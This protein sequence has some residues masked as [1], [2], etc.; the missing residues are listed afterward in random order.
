MN[1][2]QIHAPDTTSLLCEASWEVCNQIGGIYTVVRSKVPTT[3]ETWG[4]R[5]C[6]IGPYI[7]GKSGVE[8]EECPPA[9]PFGRAVKGMQDAGLDARYGHWLVPGHPITVLFNP[10]S[11]A[12]HLNEIKYLAWEHHAISLLHSDEL[13]DQVV[14]FGYLCEQF[15]RLL[16]EAEAPRT[17]I[18]GLFHEWMAGSAVPEIRRANLPMGVIFN[19]HATQLGRFLAMESAEYQDRIPGLDW[20]ETARR[21]KLEPQVMFERAAAREA[22]VFATVSKVTSYEC[23][24]LLG[25]KPDVILPNGLNIERFVALHEFQNLHRIFKEKIHQFVIGHFFPSYTFDLDRTLYFFT[26]G[27]YE[28]GNKGFDLTI[29]SLARL[30]WKMKQAQTNCTVVFFLITNGAYRCINA[31][32]L[33]TRAVMEEIR[34]NCEAIQGQIGKRLFAATTMGQSP[35]MDSLVDEY[36]RLRLRR[37]LQAWRAARTPPVMTHDMNDEASDPVILQFRACGL[38][39]LPEDPVKVVFH[40]DFI[41]TSDPLFGMDYDQFVR[42]CHF[43]MF[44][45]R[46][47]PFGYAPLECAALGIPSATSDMSGFGAYVNEEIPDHDEHGLFVVKRRGVSFEEAAEQLAEQAFQIARLGRRERIALRNRVESTAELFDWKNLIAHYESAFQL[48]LGRIGSS[49][50]GA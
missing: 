2:E 12:R 43:G 29:E 18:L 36:W 34:Q 41:T 40:P 46:Y 48:A 23:E 39:N 15:F 5:Y 33:R 28:Y 25:R 30:N 13:I 35:P 19:T 20:H 7:E 45:S 26:S 22:H 49:R 1:I 44:P 24:H 16:C 31:E 10:R 37:N 42:G 9:G 47:E 6:A 50:S 27:R 14:L 32:L 3:A 21:F 4:E 17:P 8:F 38:Q 11:A